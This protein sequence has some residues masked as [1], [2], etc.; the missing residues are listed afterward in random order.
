M[1]LSKEELRKYHGSF[2]NHPSVSSLIDVHVCDKSFLTAFL[3]R[4]L[5]KSI[6]KLTKSS[7]YLTFNSLNQALVSGGS[8]EI[9]EEF[10]GQLFFTIQEDAHSCD[11]S[12]DHSDDDSDDDIIDKLKIEN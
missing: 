4:E 10:R 11:G 8:C 1:I 9:A 6:K 12:D 2:A 7:I 5:S 3:G